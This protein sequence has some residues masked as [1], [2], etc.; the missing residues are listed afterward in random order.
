MRVVRGQNLRAAKVGAEGMV[1]L[2]DAIDVLSRQRWRCTYCSA[3]L[4]ELG[5]SLDHKQSLSRGG[6]HNK[7]NIQG[8]CHSC[9]CRKQSMSDSEY[10]VR[11]SGAAAG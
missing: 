11:L 10:R 3:N 5:A 4:M 2:D 1:S 6:A 7:E 8:L 9:N